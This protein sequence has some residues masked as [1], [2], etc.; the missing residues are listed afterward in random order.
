MIYIILDPDVTRFVMY[1]LICVEIFLKP[2]LAEMIGV[3][4]GVYPFF[5]LRL[6]SITIVLKY[7][8]YPKIEKKNHQ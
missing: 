4:T 1:S 5:L 2:A 8:A 3:N 6:T 7:W